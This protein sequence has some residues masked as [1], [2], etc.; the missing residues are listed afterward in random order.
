MK[1]LIIQ[2]LNNAKIELDKNRPTTIHDTITH[3]ISIIDVNPLDLN[4]FI[5]NNNI[6]NTA[7]FRVGAD[8]YGDNTDVMLCWDVDNTHPINDV[9]VLEYNRQ[10]FG[11]IAWNKIHEVLLNNGYIQNVSFSNHTNFNIDNIYDSYINNE[12][13]KLFDYY[14]FF[15]T[16]DYGSIYKI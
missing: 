11:L 16:W 1:N 3:S 13:D 15:Y 2:C 4:K 14:S 12:F 10:K 9:E 7:Y 8:C 6:P 5:L